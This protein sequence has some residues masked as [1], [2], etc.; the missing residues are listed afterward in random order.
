M[1]TDEN[2]VYGQFMEYVRNDHPLWLVT[3]PDEDDS[4]IKAVLNDSY[5]FVTEDDYACY[6]RLKQ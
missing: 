2:D 5:E 1:T 4:G 6:Y 3:K